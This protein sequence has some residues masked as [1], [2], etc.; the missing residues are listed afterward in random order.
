V[1]LSIRLL[2]M[3]IF[4]CVSKGAPAWPWGGNVGV[5]PQCYAVDRS[6]LTPV[7]T[8][9]PGSVGTA[10]ETSPEEWRRYGSFSRKGGFDE[11]HFLPEHDA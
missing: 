2:R 7:R 3:K 8:A 1:H 11:D 5:E 10:F 9:F 6:V 4:A